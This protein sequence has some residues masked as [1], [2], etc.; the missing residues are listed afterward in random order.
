MAFSRSVDEASQRSGEDLTMTDPFNH[1]DTPTT[2]PPDIVGAGASAPV[3]PVL[4]APGGA[5]GSA[6]GGPVR[7]G[8][9]RWI[10]AGAATVAIVLAV[11]ASALLLGQRASVGS[12]APG[13]LP[14]D[15]LVYLDLRL[16]LPGDQGQ[17]LAG[18]LSKFPGFADQ[19]ALPAKLDDLMTR[20]IHAASQNKVDY[21]SQIKPWF[22]GQVAV[23]L[24]APSASGSGAQ[25]GQ[26]TM[27]SVSDQAAAS[28]ALAAILKEAGATVTS[29]DTYRGATVEQI[30]GPGASTPQAALALS[31]EMLLVSTSEAQIKSALDLQ[32]G[33][34]SSLAASST[35]TDELAKLRTD[36]LGTLY[37]DVPGILKAADAATTGRPAASML[38]ALPVPIGTVAGEV[39]AQGNALVADIRVA[40]GPG[41]PSLS[42][43]TSDLAT[44]VPAST[45][46]YVEMHD[47]GQSLH[48]V[49]AQLET[50]PAFGDL[51]GNAQFQA[52]EGILGGDPKD[53]FSWVKDAGLFAVVGSDGQPQG[54][55]VAL[56]GDS[57]TGQA[58]VSQWL[59]LLRLAATQ[60]GGPVT[61]SEAQVSG[62][63][64][65][66]IHLDVGSLSAGLQGSVLGSGSSLLGSMGTVDVSVAFKGDL[67]AVGT[68]SA[69]KQVLAL[70]SGDSLASNSRYQAALS[71]AGG[72]D[73][74]GV[75]WLDLSG[76]KDVISKAVPTSDQTRFRTDVVPYLDVLDHIIA[77]RSADGGTATE[78]I[79]LATH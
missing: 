66:T 25:P 50:S 47:V 43:R 46:A 39:H 74:T 70:S 48:D 34:G 61:L 16:D 68:D 3:A 9:T 12:S 29:S 35:F 77:V 62:T 55:L 42:A 15:T 36:R 52:I 6:A 30:S 5:S 1:P 13:Y 17:Q 18:F 8:P 67:L 11:V 27:F 51:A 73:D 69:V 28:T 40:P 59:G 53:L 71:A 14:A 58:R 20:F 38:A 54:A 32:A 37:V 75:A 72:P 49:V 19:A 78:V 79:Q 2:S 26:L 56:A 10:V 63:T 31:P 60:S 4:A 64:V 22:G 44:H 33:Q 23:G 57:G 41:A 21:A 24:S 65:T 76:L 7:R 45:V